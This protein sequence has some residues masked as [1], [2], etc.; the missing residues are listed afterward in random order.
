MRP[1]KILA[2][3]RKILKAFPAAKISNTFNFLLIPELKLPSNFNYSTTPLLLKLHPYSDYL[4]PDAY[5]R[6]DLR[7]RKQGTFVKSHHLSEELT[8]KEMLAKGWVKLCIQSTWGP[9]FSLV[10]A[11]VIFLKFLERLEE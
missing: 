1:E 5:V 4:V 6:N 7:I 11:V 2:E 10:D 8:E 3:Y 9:S